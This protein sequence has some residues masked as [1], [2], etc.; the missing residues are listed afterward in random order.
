VNLQRAR[1]SALFGTRMRQAWL[2]SARR[3]CQNCGYPRNDHAWTNCLFFDEP[4]DSRMFVT[5]RL[6]KVG[7]LIQDPL[8]PMA[9][10]LIFGVTTVL[11]TEG[12]I[13]AGSI[14]ISA[15]LASGERCQ[16]VKIEAYHLIL[17]AHEVHRGTK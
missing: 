9:P 7:D 15:L 17:P 10:C 1:Q 13:T 2:L 16:N 8:E 11:F 3:L 5:T 12:S 6:P 4:F 14:F